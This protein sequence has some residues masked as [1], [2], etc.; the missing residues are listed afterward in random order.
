MKTHKIALIVSLSWAAASCGIESADL[1]PSLGR[2]ELK[3]E[4][5]ST[6]K[7]KVAGQLLDME[8]EYLPKVIA[9]ENDAADW[10]AMLANIIAARTYAY[11]IQY[12][13]R[14]KGELFDDI[15][16]QTFNCKNPVTET[17]RAAIRATSG[18]VLTYKGNLIASFYVLGAKV[19]GEGAKYPCQGVGSAGSEKYVTYN[20][21]NK[22]SD[23]VQSR[24]GS[25]GDWNTANRGCLSQRSAECLAEND[26]DHVQILKH[27]YGDIDDLG[28]AR[29]QGADS[30]EF[31]RPETRG[32]S[33]S[34]DGKCDLSNHDCVHY[35]DTGFECVPKSVRC[36]NFRGT[37]KR[38]C[39]CTGWE[40]CTSNEEWSGKCEESNGFFDCVIPE[41]PHKDKVSLS[42]GE[43]CPLSTHDCLY[44]T[45]ETD[46]Y[47][48]VK[49]S[50]SSCEV[51]EGQLLYRQC[52]CGGF[53]SCEMDYGFEGTYSW[54]IDCN[55][56]EGLFECADAPVAPTGPVS[57]TCDGCVLAEN[58][59]IFENKEFKCVRKSD[60][61]N[62]FGGTTAK[63][64]E[65]DGWMY[66]LKS[67][68]WSGNCGDAPSGFFECQ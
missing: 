27:F 6:C 22:G 3:P 14:K 51:E 12:Q 21:D 66:C 56:S 37:T 33:L 8:T 54:S 11:Y 39:G 16:D 49:K 58:D 47:E 38:Q 64:C 5:L 29:C 17:I 46:A 13:E 34:C 55:D 65:C 28:S 67:G 62:S 68:A 50:G 2:A 60:Q 30:L 15:R 7:V 59:C 1:D 61:C 26:Y 20:E 24:I 4:E 63:Q 23:V 40:Y 42:C 41:D 35:A 53:Q 31:P 25:I 19:A 9:C 43:D 52:E 57:A 18:Q 45:G 44:R 48:C 36:L 32:I 10:E